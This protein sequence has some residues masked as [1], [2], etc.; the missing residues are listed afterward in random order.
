MHCRK[1][2]IEFVTVIPNHRKAETKGIEKPRQ[3]QG[4][5]EKVGPLKTRSS[6]FSTLRE[7]PILENRRET[8]ETIN[9]RPCSRYD[10]VPI[11]TW[12][13]FPRLSF[14]TKK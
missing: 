4:A 9:E 12:I 10:C 6:H 5:L 3:A 2:E 13:N 8:F 7:R 1:Q 14:L 11:L